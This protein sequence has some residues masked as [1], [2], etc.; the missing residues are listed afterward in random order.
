LT[1]LKR[2]L[3]SRSTKGFLSGV[4]LCP[5]SSGKHSVASKFCEAT[6]KKTCVF[7]GVKDSATLPVTNAHIVTSGCSSYAVFGPPQYKNA[8]DVKSPRNFLPLCGTLGRYPGSCNDLF[9][10]Y[11]LTL[12]YN[13]FERNYK[14][15][16]LVSGQQD[17]QGNLLHEKV[18]SLQHEPYR[19]L[20]AWRTRKCINVHGDLLPDGGE[21]LLLA[22]N[23]S[24]ESRSV[25]LAKET[26]TDEGDSDEVDALI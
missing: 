26:A 18:I 22:S 25:A 13:P 4:T 8:L 12:L 3:R 2:D 17:L 11:L 19:R 23:F 5:G 16:C 9:D 20:L 21:A 7:C 14:V 6:Y 24:E 1:S 10:K 15:W